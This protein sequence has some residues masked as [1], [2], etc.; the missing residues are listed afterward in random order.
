M[1]N[2]VDFK[3]IWDKINEYNNFFIEINKETYYNM[4]KSS[5]IIKDLSSA[6]EK[7]FDIKRA[8]LVQIYSMKLALEN[9]ENRINDFL[10][11]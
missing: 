1:D 2:K 10:K 9:I 3:E 5:K 7:S 4:A 6:K 11:K 8:L